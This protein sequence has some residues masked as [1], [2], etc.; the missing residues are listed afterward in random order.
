M[1]VVLLTASG[2]LYVTV[3]RI[4]RYRGWLHRTG[5]PPH[6]G[7]RSSRIALRAVFFGTFSAAALHAEGRSPMGAGLRGLAGGVAWSVT[8]EWYRLHL[9]RKNA[10]KAGLIDVKTKSAAV[11]EP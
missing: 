4:A 7:F 8:M 3:V 10:R 2:L 11:P 9:D 6:P 1:V 5:H